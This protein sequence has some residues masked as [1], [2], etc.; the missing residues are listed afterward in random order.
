M[1]T[2]GEKHQGTEARGAVGVVTGECPPDVEGDQERETYDPEAAG[3]PAERL[4]E[5]T[6]PLQ[7]AHDTDAGQ[8]P[9]DTEAEHHDALVDGG[10][11]LDA[12]HG[13]GEE[14]E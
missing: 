5:V 3:E 14:G 7:A 10:E 12:V 4:L 1:K 6:L 2:E 9:D 13:V 11:V 8:H